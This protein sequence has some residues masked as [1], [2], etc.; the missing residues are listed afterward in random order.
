MART[1]IGATCAGV[2]TAT[3]T[4]TGVTPQAAAAAAVG[5]DCVITGGSN[6]TSSR[7]ALVVR[8]VRFAFDDVKTGTSVTTTPSDVDSGVNV[9][10][11]MV[12]GA[13]TATD[14]HGT[15]GSGV[16]GITSALDFSSN[17]SQTPSTGPLAILAGSTTLGFNTL[18]KFTVTCWFRLD[19]DGLTMTSGQNPR[20]WTLAP[21]GTTDAAGNTIELKLGDTGTGLYN[22]VPNYNNNNATRVNYLGGGSIP[23]PL[24]IPGSTWR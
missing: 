15:A 10:L 22:V 3:L 4:I 2:T 14:F 11:G 18:S 13:N 8:L 19:S 21:N 6:P 24:R 9:S 17:A 16:N 7:V 1:P 12:N 5:Y 23:R 20:L